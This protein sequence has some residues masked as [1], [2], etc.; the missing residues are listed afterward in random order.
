MNEPIIVFYYNTD[1]MNLKQ[2]EFGWF[3]WR[4]MSSWTV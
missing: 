1:D 3:N 2:M 4:K